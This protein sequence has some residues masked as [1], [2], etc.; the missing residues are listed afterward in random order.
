[1]SNFMNISKFIQ[2]G[3]TEK[4]ARVYLALLEMNNASAPM[5]AKILDLPKSTVYEIFKSLVQKGL[6]KSYIKKSR[7]RYSAVNPDVLKHK[8]EKQQ[9][10]LDSMFPEL[11]ALYSDSA[12]HKPQVRFYSGKSG[13]KVILDEILEEATEIVSIGSIHDI[14][15]KLQEYF[16]DFSHKR[17]K[18]NIPARII[19]PDS[20]MARK[21]QKVGKN[22]LLTVKIRSTSIPYHSLFFIWGKKVALITLEED[23]SI[24]I[25]ESKDVAQTHKAMFEWLWADTK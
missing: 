24:V 7:K 9:D 21:R 5:I 6:V 19:T 22:E 23:L 3:F 14:F 2:L 15:T 13:V 20:S 8:V 11:E 18:K 1:M 12:S 17:S 10:A 25:I 16:P 4:E